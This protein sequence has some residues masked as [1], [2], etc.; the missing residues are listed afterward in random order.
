MGGKAVSDTDKIIFLRE[1]LSS[2]GSFSIESRS[3]Q[4]ILVWKKTPKVGPYVLNNK[5]FKKETSSKLGF[6][7][8]GEYQLISLSKNNLKLKQDQTLLTFSTEK[9]SNNNQNIISFILGSEFSNT[10]WTRLPDK[11]ISCKKSEAYPS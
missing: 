11:K 8:A 4:S 10:P 7:C 2:F 6:I 9:I 5:P 3:N 1:S